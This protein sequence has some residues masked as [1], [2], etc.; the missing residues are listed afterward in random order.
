MYDERFARQYHDG[1]PSEF[2]QTSHFTG[3][4]HNLSSRIPFRPKGSIGNAFTVYIH[5]EN[6]NQAGIAPSGQHEISVLVEPTLLHL[7]YCLTD[8]PPQPNSP[9]DDV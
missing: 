6:Q 2:L 9:A 5:T 4:V 3:I 7:R 1:H 8:V